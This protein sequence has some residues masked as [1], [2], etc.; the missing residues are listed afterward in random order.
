M[1]I[2]VAAAGECTVEDIWRVP[3][4]AAEGREVRAALRSAQ[5]AL[6]AI[7]ER[8][9]VPVVLRDDGRLSFF[10][11]DAAE[12]AAVRAAVDAARAVHAH[13]VGVLRQ[14]AGDDAAGDDA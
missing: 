9:E 14:A 2:D 1:A 10:P 6:T 5:R 8:V 4:V 13:L 7:L 3:A 12:L 11:H